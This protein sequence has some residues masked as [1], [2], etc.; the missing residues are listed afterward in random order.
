MS[1]TYWNSSGG[2]SGVCLRGKSPASSEMS[3]FK[4]ETQLKAKGFIVYPWKGQKAKMKA[5]IACGITIQYW[6]V[7]RSR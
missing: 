4:H 2:G 1:P 6:K 3:D 7:E 5:A